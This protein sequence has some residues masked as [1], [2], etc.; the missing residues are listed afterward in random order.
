MRK[1][2]SPLQ[3]QRVT[4]ERHSANRLVDKRGIHS[5]YARKSLGQLGQK[6]SWRLFFGSSDLRVL[7]VVL[8]LV[9]LRLKEAVCDSQ[10]SIGHEQHV[11]MEG[12][13]Y[14]VS[15]LNKTQSSFSAEVSGFDNISLPSDLPSFCHNEGISLFTQA[16]HGN[17]N[18][19]CLN[20][21]LQGLCKKRQ[22][23]SNEGVKHD[24]SVYASSTEERDSNGSSNEEASNKKK[25]PT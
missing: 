2:S 11:F 7:H 17:S 25:S 24:E 13:F 16:E 19:S 18:H 14:L 21:R 8:R 4:S 20:H 3:Q 5:G 9:E 15:W 12:E 1:R 22:K 6:D 23:M 10:R